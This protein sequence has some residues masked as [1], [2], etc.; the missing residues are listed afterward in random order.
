V[1][2]G[3]IISIQQLKLGAVRSLA[4]QLRFQL[5]LAHLAALGLPDRTGAS[6]EPSI[7]STQDVN[8]SLADEPIP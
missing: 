8:W 6:R 1:A 2:L 5:R 4:K 3:C 7:V